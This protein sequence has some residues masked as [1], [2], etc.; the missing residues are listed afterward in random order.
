MR[1]NQEGLSYEVEL[2]SFINNYYTQ[3]QKQ[4][5]QE[6]KHSKQICSQSAALRDRLTTACEPPLDDKNIETPLSEAHQLVAEFKAVL[7][8]S[9]RVQK[10]QDA[11]VVIHAMK[12]MSVSSKSLH[13]S[14]SHP[15]FKLP[16]DLKKVQQDTLQLLQGQIKKQDDAIKRLESYKT[17]EDERLKRIKI[18]MLALLQAIKEAK[19]AIQVQKTIKDTEHAMTNSSMPSVGSAAKK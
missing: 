9:N 7:A 8:S 13:A 17:K 12:E 14:V 19:E 3:D 15:L 18:E 4:I 5:E 10:I 6:D 2:E 11:Q 16:E 1:S